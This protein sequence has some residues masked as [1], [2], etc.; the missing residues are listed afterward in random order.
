MDAVSTQTLGKND[1]WNLPPE[2]VEFPLILNP[3][4]VDCLRSRTQRRLQKA[5][6]NPGL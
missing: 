5:Q 2:R 3:F 1:G 4:R 6:P